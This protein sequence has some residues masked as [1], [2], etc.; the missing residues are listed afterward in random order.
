MARRF[1]FNPLTGSLDVV[2]SASA[3]TPTEVD[4]ALKVA[5]YFDCV[6]PASIGDLVVPS[7]TTQETVE[8]ISSNVYP[9]LVFGVII[10][11]L[12]VG[13]CRVLISGKLSGA[14][15]QLAGL[16]TGRALYVGSNGKLTTTPPVSGHIQR[17]GVALKSDT[18]FL[19]ISLDKVVR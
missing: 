9:N 7:E 14:A 15:Y 3:Q 10:E 18:V 8:P 17:C 11:K 4:A 12:G 5:E 13:R 19:N 6:E 1:I 16:V 2:A